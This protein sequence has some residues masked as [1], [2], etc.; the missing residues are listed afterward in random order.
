MSKCFLICANLVQISCLITV[1]STGTAYLESLQLLVY[2]LH[3]HT[4]HTVFCYFL[5]FPRF[6][7][8]GRFA[9][10]RDSNLFR[11]DR[12]SM[13]CSHCSVHPPLQI[14]QLFI[15]FV[16]KKLLGNSC[17]EIKNMW[18]EDWHPPPPPILN[19]WHPPNQ[20]SNCSPL[21]I[22]RETLI[23]PQASADTLVTSAI[24]YTH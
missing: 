2:L 6:L 24:Q 7:I 10:G 1:Q 13:V 23:E 4:L 17:C 3:V 9:E 5:S 18:C 15:P 20:S 19:T 16:Y 21:E 8:C 12:Y 14:F 22:I 11:R